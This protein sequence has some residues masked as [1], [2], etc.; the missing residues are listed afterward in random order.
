[1]V[2]PIRT[3]SILVLSPPESMFNLLNILLSVFLT[4]LQQPSY[5][6]RYFPRFFS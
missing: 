3:H 5:D 4:S 6:N 1:L 2:N